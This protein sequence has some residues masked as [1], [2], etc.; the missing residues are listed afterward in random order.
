MERPDKCGVYAIKCVANGKCYVGSSYRINGR[1][2]SH[3]RLLR[4]GKSTCR[5]LQNAWT[6]YGEEA[7]EF[8]IL[9][10]CSRD[11]LLKREGHYIRTLGPAFNMMH[12]LIPWTPS[13]E[14]RAKAVA[15]LRALAAARTHCPHGHPYDE[16]NTYYGKRPKD[17]R[18][19]ICA[20]ERMRVIIAAETP[21]QE[22]GRLD[23]GLAYHYA[24][25]EKRLA[26]QAAYVARN[27]EK[28]RLYDASRRARER[29]LRAKRKASWTEEQWAHHRALKR[30]SYRNVRAEGLMAA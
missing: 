8:T 7:F 18:C 5:Y 23:R 28:K 9:E 6:K 22:R 13:P 30:A 16:A 29:E 2:Q 11:D 12:A 26:Q 17:R 27:K 1:W 4:G 10:E 3:R 21:E 14:M 24:N 19:R 20:K 15:S 25:R